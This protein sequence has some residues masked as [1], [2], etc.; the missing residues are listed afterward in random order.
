[1]CRFKSAEVRR[2]YFNGNATENVNLYV[3]SALGHHGISIIKFS[4]ALALECIS[5]SHWL[6]DIFFST[7]STVP[8]ATLYVF[9]C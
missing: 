9:S 7:T 1:M 5:T 2:K 4:L 6:S 8:I 3:F